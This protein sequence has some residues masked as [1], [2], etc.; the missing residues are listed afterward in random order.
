M[1]SGIKNELTFFIY[2]KHSKNSLVKYKF[3][4]ISSVLEMQPF[5]EHDQRAN[6]KHV[7]VCYSKFKTVNSTKGLHELL[8]N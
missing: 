5:K 4:N 6:C 3:L 1:L 2:Y 8:K 7:N